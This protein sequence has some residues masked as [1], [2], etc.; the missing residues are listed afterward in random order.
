M[1]WAKVAK[2][3]CLGVA[4]IVFVLLIGGY[5]FYKITVGPTVAKN[6]QHMR[7]LRATTGTLTGSG[8]LSKRVFLQSSKLGTVTD[9]VYGELDP[10][11]GPEIGVVGQQAALF[12][13]VFAKV[14][15]HI[16]FTG[17][18]T[19]GTL[20]NICDTNNDGIC[21]FMCR[22]S[23]RNDAALFDH[24]GK[25]LWTYGGGFGVNDMAC[26]DVIKGGRAEFVV[27]FNG[28]G[29][30]HLLD[31]DGKKLWRKPGGNIWQVNTCD[32][33]EDGSTEIIHSDAGGN[34]TV[35]N[36]DG[37]I[38]KQGQPDTYCADF[39]TFKW[40]W[41]GR[42]NHA[43]LAREDKVW[44]LDFNLETVACLDAPKCGD[45]GDINATYV[46]PCK[47]EPY[48]L[49]V[50]VDYKKADRSIFYVFNNSQKLIY[51]EVLP[52]WCP[53]ITAVDFGSKSENETILIGGK[54]KVFA[55]DFK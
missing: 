50:L 27:G 11:P 29:G 53:S 34:L 41:C 40:P 17:A 46:S 49:A 30:L 35:R 44:V 19:S 23:W 32:V 20:V 16:T 33:Y 12:V 42:H 3:C 37:D 31:A 10:I 21:E 45:L 54:G 9:L 51:Q 25:V 47:G 48:Y 13:D 5:L 8:L 1:N 38:V 26:G 28:G 52:E 55:Y 15:R 24:S 14:R 39:T 36:N 4:V 2:G 7:E 6:K 18:D 43:I 22:G